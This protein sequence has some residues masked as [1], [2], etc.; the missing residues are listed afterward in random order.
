M[1]Y[2]Y[3]DIEPLEALYSRAMKY[4]IAPLAAKLGMRMDKQVSEPVLRNKLRPGV[5]THHVTVPEFSHI[6]DL[7][8]EGG[9]DKAKMPLRALCWRHQMLAV[10]IPLDGGRGSPAELL[11]QLG[12]MAKEF[13]EVVREVTAASGDGRI[14][15]AERDRIHTEAEQLMRAIMGVCQLVDVAADQVTEVPA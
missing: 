6:I 11:A 9:D 5:Q 3:S 2:R 12:V 1:T 7:L 14:S 15:T 10:D 4:G 8:E 13:G